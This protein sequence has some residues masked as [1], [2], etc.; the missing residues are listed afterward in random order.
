[1]LKDSKL[2]DSKLT[3][4][5]RTG[6]FDTAAAPGGYLIVGVDRA[7]AI[8]TCMAVGLDTCRAVAVTN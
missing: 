3:Y 5:A 6:V 1:M 7:G 4:E 2:K 8:G